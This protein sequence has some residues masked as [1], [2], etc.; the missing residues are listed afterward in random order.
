[1]E[2]CACVDDGEHCKQTNPLPAIFRGRCGGGKHPGPV[3]GNQQSRAHCAEGC[4]HCYV[5]H[6]VYGRFEE[7]K[8]RNAEQAYQKMSATE[9]ELLKQKMVE[10]NDADANDRQSPP[11]TPTPV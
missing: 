3:D 2:G 4:I 7:Q 6:S 10:I 9:K 1:M 11:P 8:K 5:G